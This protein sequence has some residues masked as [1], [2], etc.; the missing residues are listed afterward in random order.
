MGR[1]YALLDPPGYY[2][3]DEPGADF[4]W[5]GASLFTALTAHLKTTALNAQV[6][7]PPNS[8]WLLPKPRQWT[9]TWYQDALFP[10]GNLTKD[11]WA[12][13]GGI[14][15]LE[16]VISNKPGS[17]PFPNNKWFVVPSVPAGVVSLDARN[18]TTLFSAAGQ[19]KPTG[20]ATIAIAGSTPLGG[21][22]GEADFHPFLQFRHQPDP[23]DVLVFG[24][25][26]LALVLGRNGVTLVRTPNGD[27]QTWER[28]GDWGVIRDKQRQG[29]LLMTSSLQGE[30]RLVTA[31]PIGAQEMYLFFSAGNYGIVNLAPSATIRSVP[32]GPWW[33]AA[34]PGQKVMGQVQLVMYPT[35]ALTLPTPPALFDLGA[36]YKPLVE[37]SINVPDGSFKLDTNPGSPDIVRTGTQNEV[38]YTSAAT[39][40]Q[41]DV[42]LLDESNNLWASDGTH[43][44]GGIGAVFTP[45]NRGPNGGYLTP[46]LRLV[47]LKFFPSLIARARTPLTLN[48]RQ[49]AGVSMECSLREPMGKRFSLEIWDKGAALLV[50]A[51]L[52]GRGEYPVE[53]WEDTNNDGVGDVLRMAAWIFEPD[54]EVHA[55]EGQHLPDGSTRGNPLQYYKLTGLGVIQQANAKWLYLPQI[56]NV[57]SQAGTVEHTF[58]VAESLLLSGID[59]S[60]PTK[61]FLAPDPFTGTA[62]SALPKTKLPE[63]GQAGAE[64]VASWAPD[65]DEEHVRYCER[66]ATQWAGWLVYE[67]SDGRI[68]YT[69]DLAL[70]LLLSSALGGTGIPY[71]RSGTIYY[72]Q[73]TANAAGFP[74]RVAVHTLDRGMQEPKANVIRVTGQASDG[75]NVPHFLDRDTLSLNDP[76]YE[77]FLGFNKVEGWVEKMA[78][79]A[80]TLAVASRLGLVRQSQR[81]FNWSE[82]VDLAPYQMD[83]T[84][85]EVLGYVWQ[86]TNRGDYLIVHTQ[87][88]LLRA[89]G[90]SGL[91]NL[92]QTRLTGERVPSGST[93]SVV[94]GSFP[95]QGV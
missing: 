5:S 47:D 70:E 90:G 25:S 82:T 53:I 42:R 58:A 18:Y 43:H 87:T 19:A 84:T 57:T 31:M 8:Q 79:D 10:Q 27:G 9:P 1:L 85:H 92:W 69:P 83:T 80:D 67:R 66:V 91:G 32:P 75:S 56:V 4:S 81:K 68:L 88:E 38:I 33:I 95:G 77:N 7:N 93:R 76:T 26:N 35:V 2:R 37:P 30:E 94:L 61:F 60:D 78:I 49:F 73:A 24:W 40:Q 16:Y 72:D 6:F 71:V 64:N 74:G 65:W 51:G 39:G 48:D 23:D 54:L 11:M 59:V 50:A 44:A 3:C 14:V 29:S 36:S 46:Q 86:F 41:L 17:A 34:A 28:L 13:A 52:D 21:P 15:P 63:A 12:W 45:G 22:I 55:T 20:M 62:R 89:D